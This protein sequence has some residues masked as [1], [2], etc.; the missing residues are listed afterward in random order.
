MA[1][2]RVLPLVPDTETHCLQKVYRPHLKSWRNWGTSLWV[3][4]PWGFG[5]SPTNHE[6]WRKREFCLM[7]PTSDIFSPEAFWPWHV[8]TLHGCSGLALH[9]LA[10]RG[11]QAGWGAV[12]GLQTGTCAWPELS[13]WGDHSVRNFNVMM[14]VA[15]MDHESA[16]GDRGGGPHRA[17]WPGWVCGLWGETV[18][19]EPHVDSSVYT[20]DVCT[21]VLKFLCDLY[22]TC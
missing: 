3:L 2:T 13:N 7:T 5:E 15:I 19:T 22:T 4:W 14:S 12:R 9:V 1:S 10:C 6:P 8:E 18:L 11:T 20:C 17:S 16:Y 21:P